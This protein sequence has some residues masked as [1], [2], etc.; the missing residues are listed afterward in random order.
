M[1]YLLATETN[2]PCW[3]FCLLIFMSTIGA[4]E[5]ETPLESSIKNVN[6][7]QHG[8]ELFKDSHHS[9]CKS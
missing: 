1:A 8:K 3:A 4:V 7:K 2:V 6:D 9:N 5:K